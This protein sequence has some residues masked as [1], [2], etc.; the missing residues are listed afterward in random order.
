MERER[1]DRSS[2]E[3]IC[4]IRFQYEAFD[5]LGLGCLWGERD[6]CKGVDKET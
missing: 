3:G 1:S 2:L 6:W 4:G 5:F